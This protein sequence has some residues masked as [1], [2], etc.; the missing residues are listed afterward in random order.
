MK[1]TVQLP[2]D[3]KALQEE[4]RTVSNI[5]VNLRAKQSYWE[6]NYGYRAREAKKYWEKK[7]DDWINQHTIHNQNHYPNE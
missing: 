1:T 5:L 7:A 3:V 4:L 6:V 2:D